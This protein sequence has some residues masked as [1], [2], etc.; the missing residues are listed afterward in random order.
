MK[1]LKLHKNSVLFG[2]LIGFI[3]MLCERFYHAFHNFIQGHFN[4][5]GQNMASCRLCVND[6]KD[7][8]TNVK[9]STT[10][11]WVKEGM[12]ADEFL[13]AKEQN[14]SDKEKSNKANVLAVFADYWVRFGS[15][16][17]EGYKN[18]FY[19]KYIEDKDLFNLVKESIYGAFTG[20]LSDWT[21]DKSATTNYRA[22]L[23]CLNKRDKFKIALVRMSQIVYNIEKK[24]TLNKKKYYQEYKINIDTS[25]LYEFRIKIA[26]A[27][28]KDGVDEGFW[29]LL[30]EWCGSIALKVNNNI[31]NKLGYSV[32]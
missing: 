24:I 28:K 2:L 6:Y 18:E 19:S 25:L 11:S 10:E 3:L 14:N 16:I 8:G 1:K 30:A 9:T 17:V 32:F 29:D 13:E 21:P 22:W 12:T 15:N 20:Y 27:Y 7:S 23:G 5:L 31:Q 26:S 4:S